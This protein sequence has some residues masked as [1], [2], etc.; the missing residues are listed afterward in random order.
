MF[1]N[2]ISFRIGLWYSIIFFINSLALLGFIA[3]VYDHSLQTVDREMLHGKLREYASLFE[4][5]GVSGLEL[6]T[7]SKAIDNAERFVVRLADASGKTIYIYSPDRSDDL[8]APDVPTI[9]KFLLKNGP[10]DWQ[11]VLGGGYG[12]DVEVV[13]QILPSGHLLQV[14]KDTEDRE[15]LVGSFAQA[16][17]LALIPLIFFSVLAGVFLSNRFLKPIRW[18]TK[19]AESIRSGDQKA[20]VQLSTGNDELHRLATLFNQMIEQNEKLIQSMRDTLDNVAHDLRTPVMRLQN[21][22]EA[23]LR[24]PTT[25]EQLRE[26]LVDCHENSDA[27]IKLLEGIMEISEA[28]SG[29]LVLKRQPVNSEQII[30]NTID[31]YSFVAE[32]KQIAL[33]LEILQPFSVLGD[34]T[35]LMR[36]VANLLD[37]AIKYSPPNSR[38]TI[39]SRVQGGFGVIEVSDQGFG[40]ASVDLVRIWDRLYR[41]DQSRS[42]RGLGLGLSLVLA[43]AKAHGGSA[44]VARNKDVGMT[45]SLSLPL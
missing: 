22:V 41:A 7:A 23:A 27:I 37:N 5:H 17:L 33:E 24:G 28:D 42:S 26:A 39:R 32:E 19:T 1:S 6:P 15:A 8:D 44:S 31:L 13:S 45:F 30:L 29:T 18:L 16:Y 2:R 34:Q 14:G 4:H 10:K 20:R 9:E 38:I 43:I 36:A 3:Y 35:R 21:A 25:Q 12:D 40:V 11:V